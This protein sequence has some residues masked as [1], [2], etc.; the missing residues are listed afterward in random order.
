[1]PP[2]GNTQMAVAKRKKVFDCFVKLGPDV[3]W[4]LGHKV[5]LKPEYFKIVVFKLEVCRPGDGQGQSRERR[6]G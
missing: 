3:A 5:G 1:M 4:T 2:I 6:Q